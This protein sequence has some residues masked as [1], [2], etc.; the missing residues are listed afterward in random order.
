MG[1]GSQDD[2]KDQEKGGPKDAG[3]T[4]ELVNGPAKEEHAKDL[5]NQKGVGHARLDA[6]GVVVRVQRRQH[7]VHLA[8]HL[9][10]VAVREEGGAGDE[11]HGYGRD[12]AASP[13]D[14]LLALGRDV[15]DGDVFSIVLRGTAV[16]DR[17]R[18][19]RVRHG[20]CGLFC[21][22]GCHFGCACSTK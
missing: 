13:D 9:R 2:A 21:R 16:V 7:R 19:G 12:L 17:L 4:A 1:G 20:S 14:F 11:D 3:T 10:V 8:D 5:A 18:N 22:W 6:L 15:D